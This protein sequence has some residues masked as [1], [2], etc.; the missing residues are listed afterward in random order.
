MQ[1]ICNEK[2]NMSTECK[3]VRDLDCDVTRSKELSLILTKEEKYGTLIRM[4]HQYRKI[5]GRGK[6]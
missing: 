4:V 2:N 3:H 1:I 5:S 6:S